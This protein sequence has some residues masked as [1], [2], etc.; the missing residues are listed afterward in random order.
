MTENFNARKR[1]R[2]SFPNKTIIF[3]THRLSKVRNA[4]EILVM[5]HGQIVEKGKHDELIKI[6]GTY[7]KLLENLLIQK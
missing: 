7:Q 2:K 4:D 5:R 6:N 3:I 1:I